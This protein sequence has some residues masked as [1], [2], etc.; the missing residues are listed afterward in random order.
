MQRHG[1]L[2]N[3]SDTA[4]YHTRIHTVPHT[5]PTSDRVYYIL[6]AV[7]SA[8]RADV[9]SWQAQE[10][11]TCCLVSM[12]N[13]TELCAR[14]HSN[15]LIKCAMILH[16]LYLRHETPF[17]YNISFPHLVIWWWCLTYWSKI[18]HRGLTNV[19]PSW[20]DIKFG[21]WQKDSC[22]IWSDPSLWGYSSNKMSYFQSWFVKFQSVFSCPPVC[23][24]CVIV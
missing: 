7:K 11:N 5:H 2:T 16:K 1:C 10:E 23:L 15:K 19:N 13:W 4:Y 6:Q 20:M 3:S 24:L 21:I 12:C 14:K 9:Y 22:R 8:V 17:F 18:S